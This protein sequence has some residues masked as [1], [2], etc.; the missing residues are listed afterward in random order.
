MPCFSFPK[1]ISCLH[2]L[3]LVALCVPLLKAIRGTIGTEV[4][5]PQPQWLIQRTHQPLGILAASDP[6][7]SQPLY[8]SET[9][10]KAVH[11]EWASS[12]HKGHSV[13]FQLSTRYRR[14]PR[15]AANDPNV[16]F[17]SLQAS[18]PRLAGNLISVLL[19]ILHLNIQREGCFW[20]TKGTSWS[21]SH[22]SQL[23]SFRSESSVSSRL[24]L[25]LGSW[26]RSA[27][28]FYQH[29]AQRRAQLPPPGTTDPSAPGG[30][31]YRLKGGNHSPF[32]FLSKAHYPRPESFPLLGAQTFENKSQDF[33]LLPC[34]LPPL[35]SVRTGSAPCLNR[36][37]EGGQAERWENR[38]LTPSIRA[39]LLLSYSADL[40]PFC[41]TQSVHISV[42]LN[43][44]PSPPPPSCT[45]GGTHFLYTSN[46]TGTHVY[47]ALWELTSCIYSQ[48][49]L[50]TIPGAM[51]G[52]S[53][54]LLHRPLLDCCWGNKPGSPGCHWRAGREG[55]LNREFRSREQALLQASPELKLQLH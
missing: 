36:G 41:P 13:C 40:Y 15:A 50:H 42:N 31:D 3:L 34:H 7:G 54:S 47:G 11:P 5:I 26:S 6:A 21:A 2:L 9:P 23:G 32:P 25:R 30:K 46:K 17:I 16:C 52:V 48:L 28:A 37:R 4:L 35:S 22:T 39:P 20:G 55:V 1:F 27:S 18:I 45:N 24:F 14:P 12:W 29:T 33:S 19:G 43:L 10:H 38:L 8:C 44:L 53:Q 49:L 51:V